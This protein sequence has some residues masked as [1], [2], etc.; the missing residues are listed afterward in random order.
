MVIF[1]H[2]K[3]NIGLYITGKRKDGYHDLETVFYPVNWCDALEVVEHPEGRAFELHQSGKKL[4][5]KTE[6]NILYKTWQLVAKQRSLPPLLVHLRKNIPTGAGLGG[7]SADAAFF[8]RLLNKKFD[9]QFST[10]ELLSFAGELGSDCPF[11]IQDKALFARGRGNEFE[12]IRLNLDNYYL[13]LVYPNI[14]SNTAKAFTALKPGPPAYELKKALDE[15]IT[16]W[17]KKVK[18]DF[19]PALFKEYPVLANIKDKLY[20]G[21]AVYASMSGSGSTLYG[22]FDHLPKIDL[23][24]EYLRFLREPVV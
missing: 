24:G 23:P 5:G 21:G 4:P 13:L 7:G 20:A 16:E 12:P 8:L 15:P 18:N 3:I 19:E 6:D 1:P 17:R 11:F 10:E 9:L 14:H 22:I 2:C